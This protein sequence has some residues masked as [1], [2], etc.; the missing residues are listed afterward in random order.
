MSNPACDGAV[1]AAPPGAPPRRRTAGHDL[2]AV[3]FDM[4]GLL[5]DS[6][7]M[8][9]ETERAVMARMGGT[10]T[11]AD[12]EHLLGGSMPHSVGYMRAVAPRPAPPE[13]VARWLVDGMAALIRERGVPLKPGAR[14]LLAEV[15]AAGVPTALVTSSERAIMSAVL[16]ATG[17]PFTVTV[18]GSDVTRN[19]PD[20]EPY[21][22]AVQLLGAEPGRCVALDDSPAGVA[23]AEGAGCAVVAVPSV[24]LPGREGRRVV[25][26]LT[27][28]TLASLRE[29]IAARFPVTGKS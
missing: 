6:E 29:M 24:P 8:W 19:K 16:A 10:W 27:E 17:L 23:S 18:C 12:Q 21:R 20:P 11:Q 15:A 14:R 28:V 22:R 1:P 2:Q 4:D 3:L 7:P 9:F 13:V 25:G 26:S 5:V